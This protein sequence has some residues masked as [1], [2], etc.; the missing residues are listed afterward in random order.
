MR[1]VMCGG[2]DHAPFDDDEIAWLDKLHQYGP[3]ELVI[4]GGATG[5]DTYAKCWALAQGIDVVTFW[6]NWVKYL[7]SAGPLRNQAMLRYL[8]ME[9]NTTAH[10][11]IAVVAFPGGAGTANM[12][13]LAQHAGV[14]VLYPAKKFE[15][16]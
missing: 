2:R 14:P 12:V 13:G 1:V 3:L 7:N 16:V 11:R 4:T 10:G 9:A 6:A 8:L 15:V 5:A